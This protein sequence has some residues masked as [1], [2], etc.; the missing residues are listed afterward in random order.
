MLLSTRHWT[1]LYRKCFIKWLGDISYKECWLTNVAN[2]QKTC[3][4]LTKKT[5]I[6]RM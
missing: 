6:R 5:Q 1:S 3:F 2:L 4:M